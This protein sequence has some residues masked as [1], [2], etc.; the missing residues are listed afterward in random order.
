MEGDPPSARRGVVSRCRAAMDPPLTRH[1]RRGGDRPLPSSH[2]SN[3]WRRSTCSPRSASLVLRPEPGQFARYGVPL[4]APPPWRSS[5]CCAFGSVAGEA[6]E[7]WP[8]RFCSLI[9]VQQTATA[10]VAYTNGANRFRSSVAR[11]EPESFRLFFYH[12]AYHALDEALDQL[13]AEA[14]P[15]DIIAVS[16]PHWAYLRT[17]MKSVMPPFEDDAAVAQRLLD[18]VPVRYLFVDLGLEADLW[19]YTSGVVAA[20]PDRWQ[21]VY[22][23]R[24]RDDSVSGSRGNPS[25]PAHGRRSPGSLST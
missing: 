24:V 3:G 9:I 25:L 1:V 6:P 21:R 18:S 11:A 7:A 22:A 2:E 12:D 5:K 19:R 4:A 10:V 23:S 20:Y 8:R 15:D 17:G 14:A 16:M 13:R